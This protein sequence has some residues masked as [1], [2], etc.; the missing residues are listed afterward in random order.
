M[1]DKTNVIT[2]TQD[3]LDWINKHVPG[4]SKQARLEAML[5]FYKERKDNPVVAMTQ[6]DK[7]FLDDLAKANGHTANKELHEILTFIKTG[8]RS[9]S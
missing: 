1:T 9:L 2:V 8:K 6:E 5:A 4:K 3:N 7:I